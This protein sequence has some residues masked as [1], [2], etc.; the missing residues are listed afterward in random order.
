MSFRQFGGL[1]YAAK[2]NIVSNNYNSSGNLLIIKVI[3]VGI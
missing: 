3:Y 2:N 1:Q